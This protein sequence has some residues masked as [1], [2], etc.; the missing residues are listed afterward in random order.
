M[1]RIE[2]DTLGEVRVPQNAYWGAQT[3]RALENYQISN[4]KFPKSFIKALT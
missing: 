2:K 4:L 3:Q 1:E